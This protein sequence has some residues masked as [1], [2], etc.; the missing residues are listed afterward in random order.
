MHIQRIPVSF[1]LFSLATI[2]LFPYLDAGLS[3]KERAFVT[4]HALPDNHPMKAKLDAVFSSEK[5]PEA[6]LRK[7]GFIFLRNGDQIIAQHPDVPGYLIKAIS[8]DSRKLSLLSNQWNLKRVK[9]AQ[10]L[11]SIIKERN[12]HN[13]VAPQKYLY[14]IPGTSNTLYDLYYV[15]VVEKFDLIDADESK[16][17]LQNL[18]PAQTEALFSLIEKSGLSDVHFDNII[19][20]KQGQIAFIDT[21]PRRQF[22]DIPLIGGWLKRFR[23]KRGVK[24]FYSRL[25]RTYIQDNPLQTIILAD[26]QQEEMFYKLLI[27]IEF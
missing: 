16:K 14:H 8:A 20:T 25:H 4:H 26:E 18:T 22:S 13:F 3:K 7:G 1:I 6:A 10:E 19:F 17:R 11:R 24:K 12:Y 2:T 21:E 27:T 23:G 5:E 15:V 9:I